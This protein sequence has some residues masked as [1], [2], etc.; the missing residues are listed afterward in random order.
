MN[1]TIKTIQKGTYHQIFDGD[2][3]VAKVMQKLTGNHQPTGNWVYD[4][5]SDV[6]GKKSRTSKTY[7]SA[8]LAYNAFVKQYQ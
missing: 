4:I 1:L 3:M 5:P 2:K 8:R 7:R 6:P